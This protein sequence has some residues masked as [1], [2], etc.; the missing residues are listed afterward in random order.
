MTFF[1]E[2]DKI[3]RQDMG[4][5]GLLE[6]LPANPMKEASETLKD[7]KRVLL[8]TGFPIRMADGSFIGETDGPSGTANLAYTM[9][10]LGA[11]VLV[12]TDKASFHLLEEALR[13]R[14]PK[15]ELALLPEE[16]TAAF[17]QNCVRTF[18]PTH[19][20]SLERP[21]KAADGHY[22]NMRGELTI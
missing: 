16:N 17:I 19:F 7:A 11:R 15:A 3:M 9:S 18:E 20:I 8:L 1:T 6:H 4:G 5:R 12:V 2:L 21:G 10:E 22:H 14:A 13:Y